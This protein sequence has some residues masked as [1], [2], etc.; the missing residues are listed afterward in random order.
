MDVHLLSILPFPL[1][2]LLFSVFMHSTSFIRFTTL[3]LA[4]VSVTFQLVCAVPMPAADGTAAE[5]VRNAGLPTLPKQARGH[6]LTN[7]QRFAAGL[8][9]A[10]PKRSERSILGNTEF[11]LGLMIHAVEVRRSAP[12]ASLSLDVTPIKQKRSK[13]KNAYVHWG[14]EI[15]SRVL[16]RSSQ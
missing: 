8:P 16:M 4:A 1:L 12:L 10:N 11:F 6:G 14:L 9:P 5:L 3:A 15:A 2:S 13:G 7:A